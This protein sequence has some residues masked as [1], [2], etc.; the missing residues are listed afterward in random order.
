MCWTYINFWVSPFWNF[1]SGV[2]FIGWSTA[3]CPSLTSVYIFVFAWCITT[4]LNS[5]A[6][7]K[8]NPQCP[9]VISFCLWLTEN[10]RNFCQVCPSW[11]FI[12][13][14]C[15]YGWVMNDVAWCNLLVRS[16]V[17]LHASDMVR[18]GKCDI[19]KTWMEQ[20]K[21]KNGQSSFYGICL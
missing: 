7:L 9:S 1:S 17:G 2:G 16:T 14:Q 11:A 5:H 10:L 19:A 18:L 13:N 4:W 20:N 6:T 8:G 15:C 3:A 21:K 12:S